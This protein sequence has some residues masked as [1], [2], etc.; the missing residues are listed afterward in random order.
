VLDDAHPDPGHVPHGMEGDQRVIGAGLDGQ[1]PAGVA[2][3]RFSFG[4]AGR[5]ASADGLRAVEGNRLGR[6]RA[7]LLAFRPGQV[8]RQAARHRARAEQPGAG[9]QSPT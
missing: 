1:I 9:K 8:A 7:G 2:R 4:S 3:S 5:W 6:D